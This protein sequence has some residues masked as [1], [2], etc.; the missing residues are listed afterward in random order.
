VYKAPLVPSF[1]IKYD[2]NGKHA[3]RFSYARG[4]RAPSLKELYFY[5]V[6]INHNITGNLDLKAEQSHNF[7]LAWTANWQQTSTVW[8]ID[9]TVFYNYIDNLI[10]LAQVSGASYTYFNVDVFQTLGTQFQAEMA[11][12]HFK[13]AAGFAYIGR[14]NQLSENTS[15]Q[16]FTY[17]PEA[18]CNLFYEW[19]KINMTF[20]LF[21]KYSG[22]LP[23][24][25]LDGAGEVYRTSIGDYHTADITV[26][27]LCWK[28][29]INISAG[30]KNI[31][32]VK[33]VS[34]SVAGGAHAGSSGMMVGMG[35]TYF[36]KLDINL[37]GK[38]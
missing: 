34:G 25:A 16:K 22:S 33:N 23:S 11:Y 13:M 15:V 8:K 5:F 14:Y 19:H 38:K 24:Y 30:S 20:A 2:I 21:Y 12:R 31:F 37:A 36:V 26:S 27:K 4:F 9:H 10:S 7:N 28:K 35:R 29:Q 6:D 32:D 1:H 3:F 18:K 17:S